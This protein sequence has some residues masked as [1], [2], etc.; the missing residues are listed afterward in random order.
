MA[1][2]I[3]DPLFEPQ[4]RAERDRQFPNNRD[5]VWEGV[6]VMA[7]QANNEHQR[8][9]GRLTA[10]FSVLVDWDAGDQAMPGC[11]ISDR[12]KDWASNFRAP[13]V[14]VYLST[15]KARDCGTHWVGGPDLAVEIASPGEDPRQ[16]LDFYA[17][18][19]TR[20]VLIVDR[21]PWALELYQLQGAKLVL[22]GTS[23]AANSVV[24]ASGVLPLTFALRPAA[25]RPTIHLAHTANL[26]TWV[27]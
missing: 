18:V 16:K 5:E 7:P 8:I 2:L 14:A 20:E 11:N 9:A 23:D 12:V 22:V 10:A 19:G 24:L 15:T 21:D 13:D 25:P 6:L 26:Q 4:V 17:K 27:A 3:H 1:V